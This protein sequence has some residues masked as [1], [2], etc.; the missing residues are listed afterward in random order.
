MNI[1]DTLRYK[2]SVYLKCV[3]YREN[4]KYANEYR[5][6]P[7][8]R[9]IYIIHYVIKGSG[10]LHTNGKR[11]H[12][13]KGESFIIYPDTVVY[14]YP[15]KADPWE[16]TWVDFVGSEAKKLLSLTAFSPSEP[17]LPVV[18]ESPQS[19]FEMLS[20]DDAKP[21]HSLKSLDY[22]FCIKSGYLHLILA[23]YIRNYPACEYFNST[24]KFTEQIA[25]YIDENIH[26]ASMSVDLLTKKFNTSRSTLYR[27]FEN[28]FNL[29]PKEYINKIR[30]EKA[31]KMLKEKTYSIKII[32]YSLGYEN[33][34]Y[35]STVF[36]R[37]TGLSPSEYR[38]SSSNR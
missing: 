22:W 14:Y 30:L 20:C 7:G 9:G 35:F 2:E 21:V 36:K 18:D 8:S 27:E 17:V 29:S 25:E 6:G 24:V 34:M 32:A 33:P 4:D 26:L 5:Y 13:H 3:G 23:Y 11:Y 31:K 16:Y 12:I 15:D 19:I 28:L 1:D 10:F 37:N 38:R